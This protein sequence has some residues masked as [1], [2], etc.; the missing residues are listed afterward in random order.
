[1]EHIVSAPF[2]MAQFDPYKAS[3]AIAAAE[4]ETL[5]WQALA[6]VKPKPKPFVIP[7]LA[8]AGEVTLFTGPGSAGKSLLAQQLATAL[9]AGVPTLRLDMGQAPAI[10][11]TCEDDE[12]Q[13]HWRQKH[14]C[15]ALGVTMVSLADR[16]YVASLRGALDNALGAEGQDG[17]FIL[18]PTY[19]RVAAMI[20][21]TGAK[22]VALDNVAHL[23]TGNENDR[24]E[25]TRFVNALNRLAG[26]SGAAII[27][28]GHPN[29]AGDSYS[30][31]TAWL[32]AVRSQ[33]VI[34]HDLHTDMRTLTVGKANY[35]RKGGQLRLSW[36]DCAFVH[37]DD[38]PPDTARE[39]VETAK[40]H[41]G[42]D[43]F[44][45]CLKL[46]NERK[47]NVSHQPGSNYA[48]KIFAGMPEAKG[49]TKANFAAA[50]ERL[51]TIGTIELDAE[52]WRDEHR[53][54]RR[55]IRLV[56]GGE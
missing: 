41:A 12:W 16:L 36:V 5:D 10:Y 9:A 48:P 51:L 32:N 17:E 26:E 15:D 52:L 33:F 22:L 28:L 4:I 2:D 31:S 35:A 39:L 55:G 21:R 7:M 34:E 38:L 29:K 13:L 24:G 11:L 42:N 19:H 56:E 8:P 43:A 53:K 40:A 14:I 20:R 30:G 54:P 49:H 1:M 37:E 23:F 6:N 47:R 44:K 46:C 45:R 27:L 3:E 25:V 18:S 50:M